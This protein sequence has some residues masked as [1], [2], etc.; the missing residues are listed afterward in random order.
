[1]ASGV[2]D[3]VPGPCTGGVV[4]HAAA[5]AREALRSRARGAPLCRATPSGATSTSR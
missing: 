4:T 1:M 3:P 5:G 2:A